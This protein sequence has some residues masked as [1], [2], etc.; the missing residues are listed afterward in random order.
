MWMVA[1]GTTASLLGPLDYMFGETLRVAVTSALVLA[2]ATGVVAYLAGWSLERAAR[3]WLLVTSLVA[4]YLFTQHSPYTGEGRVLELNPFGD[5][6]AAQINDHRRDLVLANIAL[7]APFG[8]AAAWRGMRFTRT[9]ALAM[10]ISIAAESMQYAMGQGRIAQ[11]NDVIFNTLGAVAGWIAA[12]VVLW[13]LERQRGV[14]SQI[15]RGPGDDAR[16]DRYD[17]GQRQRQ[18][19]RAGRT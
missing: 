16:R 1:A 5:L 6:K 15:Q 2:L 8:V 7:F 10:L 9:F 12:A 18:T 19:Y 3:N 4:I 13:S 17:D 14:T 11:S